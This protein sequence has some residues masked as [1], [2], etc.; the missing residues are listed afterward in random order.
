[1]GTTKIT[2]PVCLNDKL[3]QTQPLNRVDI[4]EL[5]KN[6]FKIDV[7]SYFEEPILYAFSCKNCTHQFFDSKNAGDSVFYEDLQNKR[8]V[9]YSKTREEFLLALSH[10]K[11]GDNVLE[12][13]CGAGYF[14][15]TLPPNQNYV[16]LEFNDKAVEKAV[17]QGLNVVKQSIEDF[18]LTSK[19]SFDVACHFHVLEHIPELVSFMTS[20]LNC[21]RKGGK[22]IIAVPCNN[23]PLTSSLNHV[24]NMPPHHIHRFNE[25]SLRHLGKVYN[26]ECESIEYTTIDLRRSQQRH[27]SKELYKKLYARLRYNNNIVVSKKKYN[28]ISTDNYVLNK[29]FRINEILN[30]PKHGLNMI[31]VFSKI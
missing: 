23:N 3:S 13:G 15:L 17:G 9:Y 4:I 28:R 19:V 16:G 2:C 24:L 7:S 26:L 29:F 27:R 20:T 6:S 11:A 21:L 10:V 22:L 8:E 5:Y 31:V 25:K 14:G 12:I 18:E 30:K 1:M